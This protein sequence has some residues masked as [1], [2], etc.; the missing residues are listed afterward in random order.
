MKG[1]LHSG[2][3][4]RKKRIYLRQFFSILTGYILLIDVGAQL[5]WSSPAL[6]YLLD[7]NNSKFSIT[8]DQGAWVASIVSL[9]GIAGYVAIP[10]LMDRIG[11]KLTLFIFAIAHLISWIL[12][13]LASNYNFLLA[14]RF[15]AGFS[16]GG[17]YSFLPPYIGEI[18]GK[19]SRGLFIV[20]S[21]VCMNL[22]NFLINALGA[23]LNYETMNIVMI[24]LPL[25]AIC[26]FPLMLETP[27]FYL[28]RNEETKAIEI[29]M[30]L[31][32]TSERKNIMIDIE[33][34]RSA[35]ILNENSGKNG[36]YL[37]FSD[38]GSRKALIIIILSNV[39][40][41]F[42]GLVAIQT[43]SQSIFK[44][45]AASTTLDA[46]YAAMIIAGVQ[47]FSRLPSTQLIDIWGRRPIYLFSGIMSAIFLTVVGFYFF[48][49]KYPVIDVTSISWL[50]LVG[51]ILYQF[52]CNAGIYTLPNV[53]IGELLSVKVKGAAIMIASIVM[54]ISFFITKMMIPLLNNS[55]GIYTT[56]WIFSFVCLIGPIIIVLITPETK[57]KNLEEV[58]EL[59]RK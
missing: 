25:I 15:F 47:I 23:F 39:T 24:S 49:E 26:F 52:M 9:A 21:G 57:G 58:L 1:V 41:A 4:E 48:L 31:N 18:S 20:F 13:Y 55:L 3:V 34:M 37:L 44:L 35:M 53:F 36:F 11:R 12:I 29:L 6:P 54:A 56:F 46:K 30:K 59:M 7:K 22:G 42:S 43:Y 32:E 17:S 16:L 2:I 14:A 40:L 27:Y 50:P 28:M 19:N 51:L 33:R 45:S 10:L 38:R 5:S 8:S